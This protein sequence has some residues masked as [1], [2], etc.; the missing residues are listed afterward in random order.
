MASKKKGRFL[1]LEAAQRGQQS[2]PRD[3]AL[4]RL[5]ADLM[6]GIEAARAERDEALSD[7]LP[8]DTPGGKRDH[9]GKP[10]TA[11]QCANFWGNRARA[12]EEK[13]QALH[14]LLAEREQAAVDVSKRADDLENAYETLLQ[15]VR[16]DH[17]KVQ[18]RLC[19]EGLTERDDA[20]ARLVALKGKLRDFHERFAQWIEDSTP[21]A[22]DANR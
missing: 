20:V 14:S 12:L 10:W 15:H 9:T 8:D 16:A 22:T 1:T 19:H 11:T 7:K 17:S 18:C 5:N 3:R 2:G 4:E 6:V 21:G 13:N